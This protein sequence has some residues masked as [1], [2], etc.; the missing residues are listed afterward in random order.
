MD[1]SKINKLNNKMR[2]MVAISNFSACYPMYK[3]LNDGHYL[4][5]GIIGCNAISSICFHTFGS[6]KLLNGKMTNGIFMNGLYGEKGAAF[7]CFSRLFHIFT[8]VR[9]IK[10][11]IISKKFKTIQWKRFMKWVCIGLGI[12]LCAECIARY[13]EIE[14]PSHYFYAL[15][16]SLW[17]YIIYETQYIVWS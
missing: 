12:L 4:P 11:L 2:Y 8:S 5:F 15:R 16:H 3:S 10:K 14:Y 6:N 7:L 1:C 9:A 13:E 17:H